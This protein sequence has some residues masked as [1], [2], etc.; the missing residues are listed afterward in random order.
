MEGGEITT[1]EMEAQKLHLNISS[2]R[3]VVTIYQTKSVPIICGSEV[4]IAEGYKLDSG[5]EADPSSIQI[6]GA[7]GILREIESIEIPAEDI[8]TEPVSRNIHK[9]IVIDKYLPE[10]AVAADA[11]SDI[12]TVYMRVSRETVD[13]TDTSEDSTESLDSGGNTASAETDAA[14]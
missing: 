6:A 2:V 4:P 7:A 5:P 12:I 1:E 10:G 9:S 14:Y 8:A 3:V 11:D 13:S